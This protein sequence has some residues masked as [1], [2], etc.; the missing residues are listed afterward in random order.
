MS[1][2]AI[3]NAVG[4][5]RHIPLHSIAVGEHFNPRK[6]FDDGDLERLSRSIARRG[7]LQ[8]ILVSEDGDRFTLIAGER[9]LRAAQR[10]GLDEI[11]AFIRE[12][13]EKTDGGLDFAVIENLHRT[14]LNPLEEAL[15][16]KRLLDAGLTRKGIAE[17]LTVTPTLI[18]ERLALLDLPESLWPRLVDRSIPLLAAPALLELAEIHPE[19]PAI[20]SRASAKSPSASGSSR[21]LGRT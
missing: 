19:L 16:F 1:T 7:I 2:Q 10:A 14:Q 12:P 18:K 5:L 20:G 4:E 21:R 17:E 9:R 13:Q 8:P 15:A 11:P 6:S 3:E